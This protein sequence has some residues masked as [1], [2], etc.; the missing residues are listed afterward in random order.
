MINLSGQQ[1]NTGATC[2]KQEINAAANRKKRPN[3]AVDC[4]A[5]LSIYRQEPIMA[6]KFDFFNLNSPSCVSR[7]MKH[8]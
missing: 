3:E 8:C 7:W 4:A 5:N 2:C 6:P 1:V